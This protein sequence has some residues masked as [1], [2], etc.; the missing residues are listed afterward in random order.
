VRKLRNLREIRE[1]R[2]LSQAELA[3]EAGISKNALGQLER[4]DFNPRPVTV[5][6]LA[7][8]LGVQPSDLWEESADMGK[9]EA[10]SAIP[11]LSG[12]SSEKSESGPRSVEEKVVDALGTYIMK[13]ARAY[14]E[15]LEDPHSPHFSNPTSVALWVTN[16]HQ[17]TFMLTGLYRMVIGAL[18]RALHAEGRAQEGMALLESLW[19]DMEEML[20]V[21]RKSLERTGGD[22]DLQ[23]IAR[24]NPQAA[25]SIKDRWDTLK[26]QQQQQLDLQAARWNQDG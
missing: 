7:E 20:E 12:S 8:A 25:Q 26:V 5:R 17:E 16:L 4:G 21:T 22:P 13:R 2:A 6:K 11:P 24:S 3:K 14:E 15:D 1:R 10:P 18:A 23:E 9:S 19:E